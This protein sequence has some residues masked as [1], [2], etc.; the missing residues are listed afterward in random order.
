[1]NDKVVLIT[2][3]SSGIGKAIALLFAKEGAKIAISFKENK[4]GAEQVASEI[5]ELGSEVL[6]VQAELIKEEDAKRLIES[7]ITQFGR[8]DILVNNAG[9][10]INGDDWNGNTEV[11][12][13]SFK[14]NFVSA[15]SVSKYAILEMQKE[16]SGV[17][18]NIASRYSVSGQYDSPTYSASKA[19]IANLTQGQAK[20]MAPWGRSNAVSPSAVRAGYWLTA[21]QNEIDEDLKATLL[22]KLVEPEDIAEA[23]FFLASD[24]SK[25]I[26]GQNI[27]VDG[28]FTLK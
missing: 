25:M 27:M 15:L 20:L 28:G 19:A 21:P 16:N 1:M 6:I 10:Y 2:G 12:E 7:V 24:K 14:Q 18:V 3:A 17:I 22:G 9:R 23:V 8:I 11:W 4:E 13:E 5:K 26:T